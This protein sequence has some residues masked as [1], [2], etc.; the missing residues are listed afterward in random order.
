MVGGGV[1]DCFNKGQKLDEELFVRWAQANALMPMMQISI[2]TWRVL[3]KENSKLVLDA[4]K[5]HTKFA[6]EFYELAKISSKTGEPIVKH[7]AYVFP[8]E[9]FETVQDQFMLGDDIMVAPVLEKGAK[10]RKVRLPSGQWKDA[11]GNIYEGNT[12]IDIPVT[13][14]SIPYF[15]RN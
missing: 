4:V 13:I 14:E 11:L 9:K 8:D 2:A 12:V 6:D 15:I 7:M 5:L 10:S 1:L 3:N